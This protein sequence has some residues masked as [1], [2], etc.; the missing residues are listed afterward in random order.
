MLDSDSEVE[1]TMRRWHFSSRLKGSSK[2][3]THSSTHIWH[4]A[5]FQLPFCHNY[6]CRSHA[7]RWQ[8]RN[9]L[10]LVL[11][12]CNVKID[13]NSVRRSFHFERSRPSEN[14]CRIK[15]NGQTEKMNSRFRVGR[16]LASMNPKWYDLVASY[17]TSSNYANSI[18]TQFITRTEHMQ[19][20][21]CMTVVLKQLKTTNEQTETT[22]NQMEKH[23]HVIQ[24]MLIHDSD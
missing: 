23:T 17:F 21:H 7:Q 20:F 4:S 8:F 18:P 3:H 22:S 24:L 6:F 5:F 11:T 10:L 2:A 1:N 16:S 12:K 9:C 15:Y 19:T 14:L 13:L